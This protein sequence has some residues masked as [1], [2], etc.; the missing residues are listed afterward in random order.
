MD[1]LTIKKDDVAVLMTD[2]DTT[3]LSE[4]EAKE[5]H[6]QLTKI[7]HLADAMKIQAIRKLGALKATFKRMKMNS[8]S[9]V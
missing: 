8:I 3:A 2:T 4:T 7:E 1:G 6:E 9:S 5:Y